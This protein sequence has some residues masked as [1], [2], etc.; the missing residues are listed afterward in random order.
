MKRLCLAAALAGSLWAQQP[1]KLAESQV[2]TPIV[3][4]PRVSIVLPNG[5]RAYARLDS[6]T[7][8]LVPGNTPNEPLTLKAVGVASQA[9][10][11]S[12]VS[13]VYDSAL[14]DGTFSWTGSGVAVLVFRN[15]ALLA[16]GVDY[17]SEPGKIRVSVAQ[18]WAAADRVL[19]VA[20]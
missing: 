14:N 7:L 11:I 9:G 19:V 3:L 18:G 15:G 1:T 5:T 4:D 20:Q 10:K 13:A 6:A 2:A 12:V 17:A 8:A 16:Q